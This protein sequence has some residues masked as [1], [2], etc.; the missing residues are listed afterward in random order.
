VIRINDV[1]EEVYSYHPKANIS[2]IEKAFV[3]SAKVHHGQ[4]R[5]SGE[6]YLSHPL[7]VAHQ[8][9]QM[10]LDVVAISAG[11]LHDT[12]EDTVATM[13]DIRDMF[14][15]EV[16]KIVDGV[17]KISRLEFR[18]RE[19]QQAETIRK[20][21]LAMA[22]DIRVLLV[23]IADRLHN[24]RTLGYLSEERQRRISQETLDIYAPLAGRLGLGR[25]KSELEDL[26]FFYLQ[27]E[28]YREIRTGVAQK[29]EERRKFF[30]EIQNIILND[31][32][33]KNGI[34]GRVKGRVKH[35]YSVYQKMI[36]QSLALNQVFDLIAYRIIV[37]S[38]R[39]CYATLGLIHQKWTPIP[40]RFKDY[41]AMPKSNMY[42]SLHTTVLGPGGERME[43]QIRTEEMDRVAEDGIAAHWR[44]KEGDNMPEKEGERFA[45]LKQVLDWMRDLQDPVDFLENL[46]L[47]LYPDEVYVFTPQ[48]DIKAFPRGAT[49]L[50]FAYSIHTDVGHTCTGAKANGRLVPL[51]Y[52]LKNGEIIEIVTSPNSNPSKDW[53]NIAKTPK[54]RA[55]IRQWF[56][57]EERE[58]S[59]ALGREMLEKEFRKHKT[60]LSHFMKSGQLEEAA[61]EFSLKSV[62]DLIATIGYGKVSARQVVGKILPREETQGEKQ[63]DSLESV[64]RKAKRH[65]SQNA[66][67]VKGL[68]DILVRLGKCCNPLP[69]DHIIGFITRGR[70]VTVHSYECPVIASS[71]PDRRVEV[72]WDRADDGVHPARLQLLCED[73]QGLL[74][75][76]TNVFS[77]AETN[78]VKARVDRSAD[79]KSVLDFTIE[80]QGRKHLDKVVNSLKRIKEVIRIERVRV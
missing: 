36:K 24:M 17:T 7:E 40:G 18:Q 34:K 51:K 42:Q 67:T 23:K 74:A 43:I 62:D 5:S 41:I 69:G 71:D 11:L 6:P 47:D 49:P 13:D 45:W 20:M 3:Y 55:K 54:A 30:D 38:V 76:I 75:S 14:G 32:L 33:E 52:E 21:I 37:Q 31:L 59:E 10:K 44:Y 12:V 8:L 66:I 1:I 79:Q 61:K 16:S 56:V 50:D 60:S 28:K 64:V 22:T 39:D 29:Q 68:H 58:R 63:D 57:K 53:L 15:T 9:A 72:A 65:S 78:I 48:G 70:G 25:K 35:A 80:V 4:I 27:P 26:S 19:K 77:S 73:K 2:L 46:R